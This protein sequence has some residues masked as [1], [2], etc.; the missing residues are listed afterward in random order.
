[1]QDFHDL[2][3]WQRAHKLT[4]SIYEATRSFPKEELYGMTSQIRRAA[5]SIPA[6]IAEGCARGGD[7]EFGRFLSFAQGSAGELDYHLLLAR[8][9]KFVKV[10]EYE[11]ISGELTEVRKMLTNFIIHLKSAELAP[12][13][14]ESKALS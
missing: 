4:L 1:M 10:S 5:V 9:L 2:K 7:A 3:V 8:D 6:N 11:R 12:K 13:A 14:P